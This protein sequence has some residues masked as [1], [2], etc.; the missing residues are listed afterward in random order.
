MLA[1]Y[2]HKPFA[3]VM[4]HMTFKLCSIDNFGADQL[5]DYRIIA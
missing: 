3:L 2:F 5:I 4:Y 1:S